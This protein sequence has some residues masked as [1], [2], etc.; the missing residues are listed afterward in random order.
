MPGK[1]VEEKFP[2][3]HGPKIG[4]FMV[5]KTDHEGGDEVEL[6]PELGEGIESSDSPDYTTNA[7]EASDVCKHRHVVHIEPESGM[8][9]QLGDVEEI[10]R[11]AAKVENAPP[12]RQIELD[13]VYPSNVDLDPAVKIEILRP[14]FAGIFHGV[15]LA[16]LLESCWVDC[17][18]NALCLERKSI[19]S[20]N[21][22]R[23]FPCAG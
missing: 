17:F 22:E 9:E 1:V 3:G 12:A 5:V 14:M 18:N 6:C 19:Q 2:L 10:P 21:P 16:N 11:A 23:M 7:E 15:P 13:L 8:P 4:L 20:K